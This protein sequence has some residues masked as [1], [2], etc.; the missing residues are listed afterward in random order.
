MHRDGTIARPGLKAAYE[1]T[2]K[3]SSR[4]IVRRA[5]DKH[6]VHTATLNSTQLYRLR[7]YRYVHAGGSIV[8]AYRRQ[9]HARFIL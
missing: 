1:L 7:M 4:D 8:R 5:C 3:F 2:T 9:T 6:C